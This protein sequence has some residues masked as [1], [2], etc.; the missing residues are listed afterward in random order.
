MARIIIFNN[1]SN[2][3]ENYYRGE[4][5]PMPYNT[6][7]TLRVREFRGSSRSNILWTTK[8]TMQSWNSQ[9]Y[10]YGAPIPVGFAFKR[11]YEG[12]HGNQSQH[13]A[14][15]AFD[16]GQTLTQNQRNSLWN[17]AR[18]SGVWAYVEP[19]SLTPSWVHFDRRFGIPACSTGGYP[20]LK[21]GSISNYVCIAQDDLNTLGFTTGGLDGIFGQATQNAVI[22]YQRRKGLVAD[23]IVGCN[24]WRSLQEDV[25]GT[26]ETRTTIN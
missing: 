24:T 17:S 26:G 22:A 10:I 4:S 8:R 16:V 5:E 3:I 6:N 20:G 15:V 1:D 14:G 23:G 21:R 25:V 7:G 12:G 2:R 19:I 9:R 11:P 18:N 13:Y